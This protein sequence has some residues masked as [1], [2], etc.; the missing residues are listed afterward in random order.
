M[1]Q[2]TMAEFPEVDHGN[3]SIGPVP[4]S[5]SGPL[6]TFSW[7]GIRW[8]LP[9][10]EDRLFWIAPTLAVI[11]LAALLFNRFDPARERRRRIKKGKKGKNEPE[12]IKNGLTSIQPA[13]VKGSP[14]LRLTSLA[15]TQKHFDFGRVLLAEIR[16]IRKG[17]PWWWYL[18]AIT[19]VI[20][21]ALLPTNLAWRF[22]LPFTWLWPILIWSA[23]GTREARHQTQGLVFSNLHPLAYQL[24][25]TWLAGVFVT[26]LTGCGVAFNLL[27]AG[28]LT[29]LTAWVVAVFF[30]PSLALALAVWS[31]ES[32]LFEVVY[33][34]MWYFGP[35]N[36][37]LP[38]LDFMGASDKAVAAGMPTFYLIATLA[39]LVTAVAGRHWKLRG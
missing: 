31:G 25:A 2:A 3:N 19:L 30:I 11:L 22:L 18:V 13:V 23:L 27:H 20:A 36:H 34:S 1:L 29:G 6:Q 4:V 12:V 7:D 21:G 10:I 32:K 33:L 39:L 9:M 28:E 5:L 35:A 24:P 8:T 37:I 16:M 15:S 14:T 17:L 26:A 38:Q